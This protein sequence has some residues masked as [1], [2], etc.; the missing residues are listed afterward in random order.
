MSQEYIVWSPDYALGIKDIDDQH[1][2]FVNLINRLSNELRGEIS[3]DHTAAIIN[4]LD[5]YARF[6]FISEE[7]IMCRAGYPKLDEHKSLHLSLIDKLGSKEGLLSLQPTK[8]RIDEIIEFL[9]GWFLN[10]TMNEDKLFAD[11]I[12]EKKDH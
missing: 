3:Q 4:E 5:A 12:R 9:A 1:K 2:V 6:H 7:N 10:H 11:F 8:E